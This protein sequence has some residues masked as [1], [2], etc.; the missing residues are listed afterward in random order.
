M[1]PYPSEVVH[2]DPNDVIWQHLSAH[3]G[4]DERTAKYI[5]PHLCSGDRHSKPA[6]QE[7]RRKRL[8]LALMIELNPNV[9]VQLF[10]A[11][12]RTLL[13]LRV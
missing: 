9:T 12:A 13:S 1:Q 2:V 7:R 3:H 10:V 6:G 4:V 11:F 5:Q 8:L